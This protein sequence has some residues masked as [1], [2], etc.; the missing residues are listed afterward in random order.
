MDAIQCASPR[1]VVPTREARV[2]SPL[3]FIWLVDVAPAARSPNATCSQRVER[4]LPRRFSAFFALCPV[5]CAPDPG[6]T[7]NP[8][9]DQREGRAQPALPEAQPPASHFWIFRIFTLPHANSHRNCFFST[10]IK[11]CYPASC[12]WCAVFLCG[13]L[14]RSQRV[15]RKIF[16]KENVPKKR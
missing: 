1:R 10:L 2:R 8:P 14:W 3:G 11:G 15:T 5:P 16:P 7:R 12:L 6:T 9:A 13:N 4:V